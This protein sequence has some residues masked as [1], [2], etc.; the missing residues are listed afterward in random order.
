MLFKFNIKIIYKIEQQNVKIDAL[1]RI[2]GFKFL[3]LTDNR[4]K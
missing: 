4:I 3:N 2:S 1:T